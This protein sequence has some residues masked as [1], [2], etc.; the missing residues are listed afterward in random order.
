M[1]AI[2]ENPNSASTDSP[3]VGSQHPNVALLHAMFSGTAETYDAVVSLTTLG[4]DRWWKHRLMKA[5]PEGREYRRILDLACG[6][7]IST[8]KIADRFPNAEIVGIDLMK[9]YLAVASRKVKKQNRKNV[10]F[11]HMPVENLAELPGE[12]DL[13]LGSFAPKLVDLERLASSCSAKISPGGAIVLHD[14]I[15]PNALLLRMGFRA[16]WLLV[17]SFMRMRAGWAETSQ[18]L[19][20]IIWE[21][22]WQQDLQM[23]LTGE[24]FTDFY[25]ETQPLQV[26]RIVRALHPV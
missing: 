2:N 14:F 15:V 4:M 23:V 5:V 22:N 20:R 11:I 18:N 12:F 21:S 8:L 26:A 1:P 17:K 25:C 13:V 3:A 19:F 16:Y 9:S 6:T 7:G 10:E 24:G